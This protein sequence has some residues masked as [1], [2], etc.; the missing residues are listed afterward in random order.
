M[1]MTSYELSMQVRKQ[2]KDKDFRGALATF[3]SARAGLSAQ[4]IA[5]NGY[6]I[7]AIITSLRKTGQDA[8][9]EALLKQ[10]SINIHPDCNPLILGAYGW[11]LYDR[12][13]VIAGKV[14]VKP[15]AGSSDD[16]SFDDVEWGDALPEPPGMVDVFR[17][18]DNWL[19]IMIGRMTE[20]DYMVVTKVLQI[21][22]KAERARQQPNWEDVKSIL[23]RFKPE[24]LSDVC[25]TT[26]VTVKGLEK[27]LE[28]ASDRE[29]WYMDMIL[30]HSKLEIHA[31]CKR[32]AEEAMSSFDKLHYGNEVWF[33][34]RL[35]LAMRQSGDRK[36]AISGLREILKKKDAW[37]MRMELAEM[38]KEEGEVDEALF[39]ARIGMAGHGDLEF[40]V[41][42]ILLMARLLSA[43]GERLLS[44]KHYRLW[45]LVR[46]QQ[47]WSISSMME[48]E[49]ANLPEEVLS[50]S[51]I[52]QLL[53]DLGEFWREAS[54]RPRVP[55]PP[56]GQPALTGQIFS[57]KFN[58]ER[59]IAGFIRSSSGSNIYFTAVPEAADR[60]RWVVNAGVM[61][62]VIDQEDGRKKA[63]R[64]RLV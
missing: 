51:R 56:A 44:A 18:A 28:L 34:R 57:I 31:E 17:Q 46:E 47:G 45:V 38:L 5:V 29:R 64:V 50:I 39:H 48:P 24:Q 11:V 61:Y 9:T 40:K 36:A 23:I 33:A 37:F 7:S 42:L 54:P 13:K 52:G 41:G 53:R 16:H 3:K 27:D 2:V 1:I 22:V 10:F 26:Q 63:I 35:A 58:N 49:L 21:R 43:K 55:S 59:G 15:D 62:H 4:E 14:S 6:L 32:L 20:Y 19:D 30:V 60:A 12:L 25:D 8:F